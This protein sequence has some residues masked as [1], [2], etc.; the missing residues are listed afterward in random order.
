MVHTPRHYQQQGR[1][2]DRNNLILSDSLLERVIRA[3]VKPFIPA[4][5]KITLIRETSTRST[6][7]RGQQARL[8][9]AA[10]TGKVQ[11]QRGVSA[12]RNAADISMNNPRMWK[13]EAGH[14]W[15]P[16]TGKQLP[17][18]LD[19]THDVSVSNPPDW[20]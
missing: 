14:L 6:A 20:S 16:K 15:N 18:S 3:A 10:R 19:H 9:A 13:D 7:T 12:R 8:A 2:I 4:Q 17:H 1:P 5:K 11:S